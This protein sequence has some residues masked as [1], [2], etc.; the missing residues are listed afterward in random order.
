MARRGVRAVLFVVLSGVGFPGIAPVPA[1]AAARPTL[2]VKPGKVS[3]GGKA[4]VIGSHL[5]ANEF[6]TVMLSLSR[7]SNGSTGALL[8]LGKV[9]G[10]GNL[11]TQVRIPVVTT[12]GAASV[13]VFTSQSGILARA[14]V[15]LT[16]CTASKKA[17]AP[18]PPPAPKKK[19]KRK[20]P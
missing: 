2:Q 7:P 1:N 15:T 20:K 12:C 8:G 10:R 13:L 4:T 19:P 16:G 18:P 9:D 5:R 3:I 6:V 17:S 14:T 11:N